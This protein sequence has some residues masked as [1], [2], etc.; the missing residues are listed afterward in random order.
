MFYDTLPTWHMCVLHEV[1]LL[2]HAALFLQGVFRGAGQ[3]VAL[4]GAHEARPLE[5][6]AANS[7]QQ[8]LVGQ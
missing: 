8:Q 6:D 7:L 4:T 5:E 3:Q 1:L 2:L